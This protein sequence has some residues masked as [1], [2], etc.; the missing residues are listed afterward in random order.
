MHVFIGYQLG[1]LSSAFISQAHPNEMEKLMDKNDP[2]HAR[3]PYKLRVDHH[4]AFSDIAGGMNCSA[5][6]RLL[7]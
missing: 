3:P 1:K 6:L 7:V 4:F 5:A 2:Q